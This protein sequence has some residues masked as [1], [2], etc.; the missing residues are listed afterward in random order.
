[1]NKAK[2]VLSTLALI[3]VIGGSL[4]FKAQRFGLGTLRTVTGTTTLTFN[5][6]V[7]VYS[8]CGAQDWTTTTAGPIVT[9][10]S[11]VTTLPFVLPTGPTTIR[12]ICQNP[13]ETIATFIGL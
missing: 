4:A 13:V 5:G 11:S 1:M 8:L 12:N 6:A 9:L 2:I 10:Y 7:H 3:A